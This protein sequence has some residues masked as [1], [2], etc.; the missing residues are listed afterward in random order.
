MIDGKRENDFQSVGRALAVL[1]QL[2]H[3]PL[4]ASEIARRL[5]IKWTTAYRT[6]TYLRKVGYIERDP[7]TNVYSIGV[8]TYWLGSSYIARSQLHD[9]ARPYLEAASAVAGATA[10]LVK[11]D[12]RNAVVLSVCEAHRD[13][14]PETSVGCNFPLHCGSKGHVLL[15]YADDDFREDYLAGPLEALTPKT[16]VDPDVLRQRFDRIRKV[17]FAVTDRDVRLFSSSVAAPVFGVDSK[18]VASITLVVSPHELRKRQ[19][20]LIDAAMRAAIG[21]SRLLANPS[22]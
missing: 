2:A 19:R 11:R 3:E 7:V 8:H 18:V 16:I 9:A 14:V 4:R 6:L 12:Q 21:T 22:R 1:E 5:S 15:A 13:H 10:Q 20:Q 17:G